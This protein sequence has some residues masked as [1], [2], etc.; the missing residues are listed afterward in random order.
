MNPRYKNILSLKEYVKIL[1]NKN[2]RARGDQIITTLSGLGIEPTVQ[3]C[4]WPGIRNIIADFSTEPY[5][6]RILFTA[7]Y[8]VVNGSPGANDNA[9]G[10]AVLLGLC[11]KLRHKKAPVKILFVD[12]EEAWFRTPFIRLGL[13]GSLFYVWKNSMKNISAVYNLEFCGLGDLLAVWPIKNRQIIPALHNVEIAASRLGLPL[14][15]A[16]I[17]WL[18]L[19]SDHLSF[20]LK[21]VKNALTLSLLPA[22]QAGVLEDSLSKMGLL[23]LLTGRRPALP[24]PLDVVHS[25]EDTSYNIDESSLNL[26]LSLLLELLSGY[27]TTGTASPLDNERIL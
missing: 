4:H 12:R 25:S 9:S 16:H 6:K 20:R 27:D 14:K 2:S 22:E 7:D 26:M 10:V 11:Q 17:P 24:K 1:E 8:D 19:S 3:K 21:G 5:G 15:I 18:L 23:R 13:L